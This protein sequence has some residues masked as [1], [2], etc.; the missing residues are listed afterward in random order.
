LFDT[1]TNVKEN[2]KKGN[3]KKEV[4]KKKEKSP[5]DKQARSL[6]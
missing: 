4:N 1:S 3:K 5:Y 6:C 2:E